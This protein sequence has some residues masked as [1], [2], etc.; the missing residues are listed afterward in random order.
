M[1]RRVVARAYNN[2][3]HDRYMKRSPRLQGMALLPMQDV[4]EAVNELRRAVKEMTLAFHDQRIDIPVRHVL[5]LPG[6]VTS[7]RRS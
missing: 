1:L 4:S 2:W 6:G 7:A 5:S 3:I